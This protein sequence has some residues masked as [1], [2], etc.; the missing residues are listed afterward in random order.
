MGPW[1][2]GDGPTDKQEDGGYTGGQR[3]TK[4]TPGWGRGRDLSS[5]VFGKA[6]LSPY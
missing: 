5:G 4:R 6:K 3:E 1:E 2:K